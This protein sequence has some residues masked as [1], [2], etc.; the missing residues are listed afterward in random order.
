ML[1]GSLFI[2]VTYTLDE[3]LSELA[4]MLILSETTFAYTVNAK[5]SSKT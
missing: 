3:E 2:A 4:A 1:K 5:V